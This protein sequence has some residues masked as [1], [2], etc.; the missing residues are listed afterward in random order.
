MR[1]YAY[2]DVPL[3]VAATMRADSLDADVRALRAARDVGMPTTFGE[4]RALSHRVNVAEEA[5]A[6]RKGAKARN[7]AAP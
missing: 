2:V 4:T 3:D 5:R 1:P 7:R 6:A